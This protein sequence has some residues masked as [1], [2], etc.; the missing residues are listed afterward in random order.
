MPTLTAEDLRQFTG[1]EEFYRHGL[2]CK[3]VYTEGIK[4]LAEAGGAYWLLDKIATSQ[5][6]R[7]VRAEPFQVWTLTK[8]PGDAAMLTCT[9]GGKA[10]KEHVTLW[11]EEV[12]FTDFPLDRVQIYVEDNV[13]LLPS[14][15]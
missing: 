6:V 15:H 11:R 7:E 14:E 9:D 4:H 1:S 10:G 12:R 3:M 8:G 2:M 5:L 13:I